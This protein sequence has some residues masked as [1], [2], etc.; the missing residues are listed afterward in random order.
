MSQIRK[1]KLIYYNYPKIVIKYEDMI[2]KPMQIITQLIMFLKSVGVEG[3][4]TDQKIINVTKSTNFANLNKMETE[5]GFEESIYGTKFFNIGKKDQW[6]KNL[7]TKHA[8][9]IEKSFAETMKKFGY[10]N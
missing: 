5:L 1:I 8:Q 2:D 6:K 7:P 4:F 10:L 9:D 3:G